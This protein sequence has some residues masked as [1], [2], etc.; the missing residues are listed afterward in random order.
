MIMMNAIEGKF[1]FFLGE[2]FGFGF[3]FGF[4]LVFGFDV[5]AKSKQA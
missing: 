3:G 5:E 4:G 1:L 2:S